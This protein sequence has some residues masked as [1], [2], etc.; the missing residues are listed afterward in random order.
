[1]KIHCLN[2]IANLSADSGIVIILIRH[3]SYLFMGAK[4][5]TCQLE[6]EKV[7]PNHYLYLNSQQYEII[8]NCDMEST[9][10]LLII[11]NIHLVGLTYARQ[12]RFVFY[13]KISIVYFFLRILI[14]FSSE[15]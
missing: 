2:K 5:L 15:N 10:Y 6:W 4:F 12:H 7:P 9:F 3:I 14:I 8:Q 1:M 13:F 11:S